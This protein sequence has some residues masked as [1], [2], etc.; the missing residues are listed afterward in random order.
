MKLSILHLSLFLA[1]GF[2]TTSSVVQAQQLQVTLGSE[3]IVPGDSLKFD[4]AYETNKPATLLMILSNK[5][6]KTWERRY[7]L[8]G[9]TYEAA[10]AI[11][12][13]MPQGNYALQFIVLQNF[14]TFS[15]KTC[16]S[17]LT[18]ISSPS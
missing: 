18:V 4:V 17:I 7:P 13:D 10:I 8:L 1:L 5:V 6:G 9:G 16:P 11:P 15:G 2:T 14:F 3:N 12:T